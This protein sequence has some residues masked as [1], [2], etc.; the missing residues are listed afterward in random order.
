M[1]TTSQLKAI[2]KKRDNVLGIIAIMAVPAPFIAAGLGMFLSGIK[3]ST[4]VTSLVGL[5]LL[6]LGCVIGWLLL[7]RKLRIVSSAYKVFTENQVLVDP[8]ATR[9]RPVEQIALEKFNGDLKLALQYVAETPE[10]HRQDRLAIMFSWCDYERDYIYKLYGKNPMRVA[11]NSKTEPLTIAIIESDLA[12]LTKKYCEPVFQVN[13][14]RC[15]GKHV[16]HGIDGDADRYYLLFDP[17]GSCECSQ[18]IHDLT[19]EGDEFFI[20]LVEGKSAPVLAYPTAEWH[21][22]EALEYLMSDE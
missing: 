21:A 6:I 9:L 5:A 7:R 18:S 10:L 15:T 20:V 4:P 12:R 16:S 22:N 13:Q 19:M 2:N 14:A 11:Q 3:H 1:V 8:K 17:C